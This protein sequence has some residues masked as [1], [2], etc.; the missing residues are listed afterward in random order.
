M[1]LEGSLKSID[2]AKSA[3]IRRFVQ[4][5]AMAVDDRFARMRHLCGAYIEAK[6][7]ADEALRASGARLDN[8]A[9][10]VADRRPM[11]A[12]GRQGADVPG[13]D[14]PRDDVA[15]VIIAVLENDA[16]GCVVRR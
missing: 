5:S 4:V 9:A 8:P 11:P 13:G 10:R 14:I 15:A 3:R 2:G 12:A 1:D 16:A 7:G 6:R